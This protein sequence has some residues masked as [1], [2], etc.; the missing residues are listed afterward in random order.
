MMKQKRALSHLPETCS[1]ESIRNG[2]LYQWPTTGIEESS[3][4]YSN[5]GC[6]D[7]V[8]IKLPSSHGFAEYNKYVVR[9]ETDKDAIRVNERIERFQNI[10]Q[11]VA[12]YPSLREARTTIGDKKVHW[13]LLHM[14]Q[15]ERLRGLIKIPE[16]RFCF[17]CKKGFLFKS[18]HPGLVQQ[19]VNGILMWDMIDHEVVHEDA[20]HEPFV[21]QEYKSVI[22]QISSQLGPLVTASHSLHINWHIKNFIYDPKTNVLYYVDLKP[23]NIF[24]KWRNEQNIRNIRRDFLH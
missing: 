1:V 13:L 14:L 9:E 23:S 6:L 18:T 24:G 11:L 5:V 19:R 2:T 20:E 3:T 17:F 21:K 10:E 15:Y 12:R 22:P 16:T 7:E 4:L 8:V